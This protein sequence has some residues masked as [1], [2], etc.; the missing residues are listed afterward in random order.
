MKPLKVLAI[1][2]AISVVASALS[3][4]PPDELTGAPGE[5]DLY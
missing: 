3:S 5:G 4:G 1:I 2:F